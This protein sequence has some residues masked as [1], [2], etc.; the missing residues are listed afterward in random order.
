MRELLMKWFN[1][2]LKDYQSVKNDKINAL[3][4]C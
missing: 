4:T 3:F 2:T 1:S